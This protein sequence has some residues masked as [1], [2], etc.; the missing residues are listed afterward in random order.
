MSVR[1]IEASLA[2]PRG[3]GGGPVAAS[4]LL[5]TFP[6]VLVAAF[7]ERWFEDGSLSLEFH[8]PTQHG[9]PV[10][11]GLVVD[12]TGVAA[13]SIVTPDGVVVA[14]GTVA[15]GTARLATNR[16]RDIVLDPGLTTAL[17][18]AAVHCPSAAQSRRVF[19]G[20]ITS[21]IEWYHGTSPWGP[22]VTAPSSTIEMFTA[23]ADGHLATRLPDSTGRLTAV[24]L[25]Y[26]GEPVVCDTEY[27]VEGTV[28]AAGESLWFEMT[29]HDARGDL[30]AGVGLLAEFA[31]ATPDPRDDRRPASARAGG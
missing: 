12:D 8:A 29:A 10:R 27:T 17:P 11:A 5:D 9:E 18:S 20:H 3:H 6:P 24:E 23:V 7:G 30:V 16:A 26:F 4:T 15:V 25:R 2:R 28:S 22:A 19:D 21:P 14:D 1:I 31:T 13:A